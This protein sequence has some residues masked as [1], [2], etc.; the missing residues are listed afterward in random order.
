[1]AAIAFIFGLI[2]FRS[3]LKGISKKDKM[4]NGEKSGKVKWRRTGTDREKKRHK[5]KGMRVLPLLIT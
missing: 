3:C 1:M 4:S 2:K 5:A